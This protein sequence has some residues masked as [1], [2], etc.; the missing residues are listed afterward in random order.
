MRVWSF[1]RAGGVA[2]K[3]FDINKYGL[4]FVF[5][6]LGF[7]WMDEEQLGFDPTI[8]TTNQQRS[9]TITKRDGSTE[10]III[11]ELMNRK[12]SMASRGT[13]CWKAHPEGYPNM[14]LVIKDAWLHPEQNNEGDMLREVTDKGALNVVRCYHH[15]TVQVRGEDD[16]VLNNV[17]QQLDITTASNYYGPGSQM[18]SSKQSTAASSK[19]ARNRIHRRIILR[20]SGKPIYEA[21]SR[22]TLLEAL[23][24][25]IEGH[26]ALLKVGVLHRDISKNNLVINEDEKN[27]SW[28]S[29][30]ID[31]DM[32]IKAQPDGSSG[33]NQK[34]GTTA[35]MA[36]GLLASQEHTYMHDL[37][38]FFW[39]LL[40]ICI[41]YGERGE[42]IGSS[43]FED[44]DDMDD[45]QLA[46]AKWAIVHDE[47][48]LLEMAEGSFTSYYRPLIPWVSRLRREVFPNGMM[49][50]SLE[51]MLYFAMKRVL[52]AAREDPAVM[53]DA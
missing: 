9:I 4:A 19:K 10:R 52:Q 51:P 29:F 15:E 30:L 38:S 46:E 8:K 13:T 11:D 27:P 42:L 53:A 43:R 35:Y 45:E 41:Y 20:D 50:T 36:I 22:M 37:E 2:S 33:S 23:E 18:P 48:G 17:R 5:T 6:L 34:A 31:L 39:V 3:Q 32:A 49:W 21:S 47:K 26:E 44:W 14:P 1:D 28:G 25:C 12:A 16:D 24:G 7:L 40:H